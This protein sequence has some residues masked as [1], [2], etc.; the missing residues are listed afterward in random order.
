MYNPNLLK[1]YDY[2][3]NSKDNHK[4]RLLAFLQKTEL[5]EERK[6]LY[7][8]Q[9]LKYRTIQKIIHLIC[10]N[11]LQ[12]IKVRRGCLFF[13]FK[14]FAILICYFLICLLHLP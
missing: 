7:K 12:H 4:T 11:G 9:L 1:A 8:N 14:P 2:F 5:C 10:V 3:L 6:M 13:I